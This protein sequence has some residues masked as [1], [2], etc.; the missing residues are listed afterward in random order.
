M[1]CLRFAP[2]GLK[3]LFFIYEIYEIC[4][5]IRPQLG[6]LCV[7]YPDLATYIYIH[8]CGQLAPNLLFSS[9]I[10]TVAP[11][12]CDETAQ[13]HTGQPAVHCQLPPV[14]RCDAKLVVWLDGNCDIHLPHT[15]H[16][17]FRAQIVVHQKQS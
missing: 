3:F 16:I 14:R 7:Y 9:T 15:G 2:L 8:T 13:L 10:W 1:V 17:I 5:S 4:T 11:T 12:P 6:R